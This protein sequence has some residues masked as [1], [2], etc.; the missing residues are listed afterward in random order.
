M[1]ETAFTVII[2]AHNEG[3]VIERCLRAIEADAP[4][5]HAMQI[6]VAANGCTD[7][8][9]EIARR[10][11][12]DA[13]VIVQEVGSKPLAMNAARAL[14]R[15][16]ICIFLDA[17]V[18]C[19][20]RSLL[21][22]ARVLEEPGVMAASP[23]IRLDLSRSNALVKSYY[24][25]WMNLPYITD[26][27]VGSGCFGLSPTASEQIG[28]FP[29]LIGD[30]ILVRSV[31]SYDERRNVSEDGDGN[32]VFFEVSPPRNLRDQVRVEVRRRIGN[33]QIDTMLSNDPDATNH[34]GGHGIQDILRTRQAGAS[35][36]DIG[37][38]IAAKVAVI[39]RAK[40]SAMRGQKPQWER[41]LAAREA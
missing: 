17:D 41:D 3:Q 38:Y 16:P 9:A 35:L 28:D 8:T 4:A 23:S 2:P 25:V 14:A 40:Y 30:D 19:S 34:R 21:A 32:P 5:S 13:L 39:I 29:E 26:R 1:P 33:Q 15:A 11:T 6:I 37:V 20:Y 27:L 22:L 7:D 36:Y 12:P 10:T 31:F 18:Q 24:K